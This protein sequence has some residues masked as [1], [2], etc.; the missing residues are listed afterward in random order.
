M[1]GGLASLTAFLADKP[2][3]DRTKAIAGGR[4][5]TR[6]IGMAARFAGAGFSVVSWSQAAPLG[7]VASAVAELIEVITRVTERLPGRPI[8]LV[9][10][11]RG[12]LIARSFLQTQRQPAELAG[13]ITLG[14]PHHGTELA[15]LSRYL[16]PVGVF[17][18]KVFK[19]PVYKSKIAVALQR[20]G[21]F[22]SSKAIVELKPGSELI[23]SLD[24]PVPPQ[25]PLFSCG[26]TNPGLFTL[27]LRTDDTWR[28]LVFPD[29][30]LRLIPDRKIPPE[31]QTG[32]GDGLVSAAS[33]KLEKEEHRDFE[34][35]HVQLA[36]DP[37]VYRWLEGILLRGIGKCRTPSCG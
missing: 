3:D 15:S 19:A 10:H 8:W 16:Q 35:N 21:N 29:F 5:E 26:G 31:L 7:P 13:C 14:T 27:Y 36:F 1:F 32:M 23:A 6:L 11:S 17:L 20:V 37:R 28:R 12:G 18:R 2:P 33:S 9:A 30:L 24:K 34:V 4:M 22:L 25:L